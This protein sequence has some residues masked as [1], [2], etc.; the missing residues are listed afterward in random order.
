MGLGEARRS[1]TVDVHAPRVARV[2]VDAPCAARR[3]VRVC[4]GLWYG[5]RRGGGGSVPGNGEVRH[6][7]LRGEHAAGQLANFHLCRRILAPAIR[8]AS[9]K[10][11]LQLCT[12]EVIVDVVANARELRAAVG[13]RDQQDGHPDQL[14]L[15]N[16]RRVGSVCLS[17][18]TNT[19]A[20]KLQ[21]RTCSRQLRAG[22]PLRCQ[23]PGRTPR[24]RPTP[25]R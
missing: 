13:A 12:L 1:R 7:G 16:A 11:D 14:V 15:G 2:A 4:S 19:P 6:M 10:G 18:N 9:N 8:N 22:P 20:C 5:C 24:W 3:V 17:V 21:A 23:A 25:H